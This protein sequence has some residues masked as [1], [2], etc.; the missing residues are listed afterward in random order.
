M[1]RP[2]Q[3]RRVRFRGNF[4]YFKPRAVPLVE[5]SE[6]TLTVDEFEAM[7]LKDK[8]GLDQIDAAKKMDVSQPTF[9]RIL[10]SARKKTAE[11]IVDGKAIKIHGGECKMPN[12]DGTG[13]EGKGP[14]TGRGLGKCPPNEKENLDDTRPRKKGLGPCGDGTPRGGGRGHGGGRR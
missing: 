9:H 7:R 14:R 4:H 2:K 11:A 10:E 8:L 6:V 5:L 13:P 1:V 12:R 3:C